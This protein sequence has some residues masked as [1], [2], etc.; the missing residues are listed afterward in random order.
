MGPPCGLEQGRCGGGGGRGGCPAPPSLGWRGKVS[1]E[2]AAPASP[3]IWG[4]T[5]F[6]KK[7]TIFVSGGEGSI[8]PRKGEELQDNRVLEEELVPPR[9][10]RCSRGFPKP[11]GRCWLAFCISFCPKGRPASFLSY[12]A[13]SLHS[14]KLSLHPLPPHLFPVGQSPIPRPTLLLRAPLP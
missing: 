2:T 9:V 12:W 11:G 6:K 10:R 14:L 5:G 4:K 13:A 1:M 3:E 8:A 7:I